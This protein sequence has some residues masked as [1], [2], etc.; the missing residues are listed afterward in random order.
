MEVRSLSDA[1]VWRLDTFL[2]PPKDDGLPG[3]WGYIGCVGDTLFGSLANTEHVVTYRFRPGGDMSKQFT[4]STLLFAMDATTGKLR[5]AL[6]QGIDH[7]L[8]GDAIGTK[9]VNA[10]PDTNL[11]ILP[12]DNPHRPDSINALDARLHRVVGDFC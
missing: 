5:V 9:V 4:E 2:A 8:C 3:T 1:S 7:V 11:P 12:T 10:E 6:L